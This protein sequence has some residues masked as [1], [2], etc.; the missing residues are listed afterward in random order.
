LAY[1]SN[2]LLA[3]KHWNWGW[4]C[5]VVPHSYAPGGN[6]IL[7]AGYRQTR[8]G[9]LDWANFMCTPIR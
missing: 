1:T 9:I 7:T 3:W 6:R 8:A 2:I 4:L 5:P